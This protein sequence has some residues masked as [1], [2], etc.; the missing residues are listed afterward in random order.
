MR[1]PLFIQYLVLNIINAKMRF[2][3][4]ANRFFLLNTIHYQHIFLA[5]SL[6]FLI[7]HSRFHFFTREC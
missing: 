1:L 7:I 4:T 3:N 2:A 5:S 6:F